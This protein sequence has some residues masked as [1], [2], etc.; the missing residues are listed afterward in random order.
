MNIHI[1][2]YPCPTAD[3]RAAVGPDVHFPADRWEST[4][5][6]EDRTWIMFVARSG[7]PLVWLRRYPEG[8]VIGPPVTRAFL[9]A[10]YERFGEQAIQEVIESVRFGDAD[11]EG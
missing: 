5:E 1:G 3:E 2:R 6:D 8:G 4:I 11:P 9:D 7:E 10:L